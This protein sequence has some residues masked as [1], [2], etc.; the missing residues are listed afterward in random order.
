M[1]V[2]SIMQWNLQSYYTKFTELKLI[3]NRYHP[4]CISL[5]ETLIKHRIANPPSQYQLYKSPIVRNDGHER[6]AAILIH[7][8]IHHE[9]IHLHTTLQA[10]A[11][12][13][14]LNK[15]YTICSLYIPHHNVQRNEIEE[16]VDQLPR[17]FVIQGDFNA[18]SRLWGDTEENARGRML[19]DIILNND[20]VI[21]NNG[22]PTHYHSQSNTYSVIDLALCSSD[23]CLDFC[24]KVVDS[25]HGSDHFP[26]LLELHETQDIT[27]VPSFNTERADWALFRTLTATQGGNNI[28][29]IN[30]LTDYV[31]DC[32]LA[33][34]NAAIQ[35][36]S[37]NMRRPPMPWWNAECERVKRERIRAERAVR[38]NHTVFNNIRYKRAKVLCR[39]TFNEA[40]KRNWEKFVNSINSRTTM[41]AVWSKIKKISGKFKASPPPVLE[42]NGRIISCSNQVAEKMANILQPWEKI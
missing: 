7:N 30:Q 39:R 5:Q 17:P 21:S 20:I 13:I 9:Q 2:N 28:D 3:L 31:T 19:E 4:A 18:R 36:K 25:L 33:A 29:D 32:A 8:S 27:R 35:R 26:A 41:K 12:T 6:G 40:K 16:L 22:Q 38:R 1:R 11:I 24:Y 23:C 10:V 34:A 14:F 15:L 42:E 37:G